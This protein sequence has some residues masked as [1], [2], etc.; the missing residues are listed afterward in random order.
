MKLRELR[1]LSVPM[2]SWAIEEIRL[3]GLKRFGKKMFA[4][5]KLKK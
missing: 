1:N 5:K 2:A 4:S 3:P